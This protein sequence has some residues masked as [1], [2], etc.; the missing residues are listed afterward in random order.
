MGVQFNGDGS[1]QD[2]GA[3][4]IYTTF[5]FVTLRSDNDPTCACV[6]T[7]GSAIIRGFLNEFNTDGGHESKILETIQF[8]VC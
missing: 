3:N 6:R 2:S 1:W 5:F 7:A 4:P 8:S